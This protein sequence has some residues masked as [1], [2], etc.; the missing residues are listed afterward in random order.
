MKLNNINFTGFKNNKTQNFAQAY[1]LA[2][3]KADSVSF[4]GNIDK[5]TQVGSDAI[6]DFLRKSADLLAKGGVDLVK[7]ATSLMAAGKINEAI[8]LINKVA[9]A[10]GAI[11][12]ID[13]GVKIIARN[14]DGSPIEHIFRNV[15]GFKNLGL[16]K[17]VDDV[18]KAELFQKAFG[19]EPKTTVGMVGW[20]NVKPENILGGTT[21]SKAELTKAYE[22]GIDEF[23]SPIHKYFLALGVNP[24]DVALTSSVSYSGVDKAIMDIGQN[25]GINTLTITPFDYSIY[26]RNEH[27]FPM[28]VTDTIPQYVDVY[29]KMSD[30]IVVTGGRDHAF[31]F[32]AGGKWTKQNDGILIPVDILRDYK[33]ILVPATING[34]IENAAALAYETFSDPLPSGLVKQFDSLPSDISKQ[35]IQHP[36]QKA[37]V[38]AMWNDLSKNG[39]KF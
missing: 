39:F 14:W 4:S 13:E 21:L 6:L 1:R 23:Y 33:G 29:G 25:K 35:D 28:I 5:A 8:A 16:I 19:A 18:Q 7:D 10:N 31:R 2:P 30:N 11:Q 9:P 32:D 38:S 22:E 20:T 34:K 37:L 12:N 24:N 3:M 15:D 26:G 17:S 36:A 27:P